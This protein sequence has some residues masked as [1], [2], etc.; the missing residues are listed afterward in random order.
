MADLEDV[1]PTMEIKSEEIHIFDVQDN[2]I[3]L[4]EKHPQNLKQETLITNEECPN[5]DVVNIKDEP[6][7]ETVDTPLEECP[8]EYNTRL[9]EDKEDLMGS[10]KQKNANNQT[11][12]CPS[13]EILPQ[14]PHICDIR[15]QSTSLHGPTE[16]CTQEISSKMHVKT[17]RKGFILKILF[18]QILWKN[19]EQPRNF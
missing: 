7:D 15:F 18:L 2:K 3:Q 17:K 19:N 1:K 5:V 10:M 9:K 6:L 13:S 14:K 8:I 11:A 16:L 4:I 12:N